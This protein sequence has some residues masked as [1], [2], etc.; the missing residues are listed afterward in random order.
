MA[1]RRADLRYHPAASI[2]VPALSGLIEAEMAAG[3]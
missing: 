2:R 3:I 1:R